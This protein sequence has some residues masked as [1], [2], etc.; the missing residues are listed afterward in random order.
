MLGNIVSSSSPKKHP[1]QPDK[2]RARFGRFNCGFTGLP[3]LYL[4]PGTVV[5]EERGVEESGVLK[6]KL[7][8]TGGN[9]KE[10]PFI[11]WLVAVCEPKAI[12]IMEH[13]RI[14]LNRVLRTGVDAASF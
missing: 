13:L 5:K 1:R 8:P 11:G 10:I 14:T 4:I 6:E 7:F 12:T 3:I 2:S 9:R